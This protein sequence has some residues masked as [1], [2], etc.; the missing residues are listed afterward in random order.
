MDQ[1]RVRRLIAADWKSAL[2]YEQVFENDYAAL[3]PEQA[4]ATKEGERDRTRPATAG[5]LTAESTAYQQTSTH[6]L[7]FAASQLVAAAM[8]SASTQRTT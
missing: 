8:S 2:M 7:S 4:K 1:Q 6:T 5:I 3:K